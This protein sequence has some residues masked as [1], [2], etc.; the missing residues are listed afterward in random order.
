MFN[1]IYPFPP[2]YIVELY[3]ELCQILISN[4]QYFCLN[5]FLYRKKKK[6]K[7]KERKNKHEKNVQ[8][9]G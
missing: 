4:E 2:R 9:H 1:K 5:K 8:N 6:V 7:K 3:R